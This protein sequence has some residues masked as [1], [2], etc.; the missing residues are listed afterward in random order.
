M[1]SAYG[2]YQNKSAWPMKKNAKRKKQQQSQPE[3]ESKFASEWEKIKSER[4]LYRFRASG[5]FFAN[6]RRGGRHYRESLHVTD[7]ALAK[8]KLAT[9]KSRIDR[10]DPRFGKISLVEWLKLY[11]D[12]LKGAETTLADKGRIIERVKTTWVQARTQPMRDLKR[13][14]IVTWLN[15]Q[16]GGWSASYYNTALSLLRDAFKAA[17]Q[18]RVLMDNPIADLQYRRRQRPIRLTPTFA[19]F[20]QII[21]DVRAQKFNREAQ[22]SA[23]FLAFMGL[24]GLGQAEASNITRG[25]VDLDANRIAIFRRK[26]TVAF[27]VPI[28]P[29]LRALLEKLCAGKKPHERLFSI[30]EA[31][32]ALAQSCKRLGFVRESAD[33][34]LTPAFTQRSLRRCFVTRALESGIDVQTIARWQGHRDGGK[35]ILDTYGDVTATHSQRMPAL[36]TEET[37]ANVIPL[38]RSQQG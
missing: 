28:Y 20:G 3:S 9:L 21:A 33:G 24:A 16:F 6:F 23:D 37:P 8:R 13:S 29:Q 30:K 2:Y 34:E 10:T 19:Q 7:L 36:L 26:T 27:F 22:E 31:R 4:G 1:V 18:D 11:F 14:Q 35:L 25:H 12:T 17:V 15:E 5:V 38:A 32:K